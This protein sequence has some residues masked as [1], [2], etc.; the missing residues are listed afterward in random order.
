MVT[1]AEEVKFNVR[2]MDGNL[3]LNTIPVSSKDT[4]ETVYAKLAVFTS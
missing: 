2:I 3:E 1:T 4:L